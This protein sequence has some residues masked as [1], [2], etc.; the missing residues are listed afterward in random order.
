MLYEVITVDPG[1]PQ[2]GR[3][4]RPL[5]VAIEKAG[6]GRKVGELSIAA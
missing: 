2:R 1:V 4:P 3:P 5:Y 6:A